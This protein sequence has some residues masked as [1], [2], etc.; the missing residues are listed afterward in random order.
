M[1]QEFFTR[2]FLA[3][4]ADM[5]ERNDHTGALL[6]VADWAAWNMIG[7]GKGRIYAMIADGFD[8]IRRRQDEI[9]F[10]DEN[11]LRC[12]CEFSA[13][14]FRCIEEDFGRSCSDLVKKCL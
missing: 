3:D 5:T 12:R 1:K 13:M 10:L 4:L 8:N 9:G 6:S 2:S 7:S 14:L 11:L